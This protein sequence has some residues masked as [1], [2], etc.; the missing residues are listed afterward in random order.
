MWNDHALNTWNV[1]ED[2]EL[3]VSCLIKHATMLKYL[4]NA[5]PNPGRVRT[6]QKTHGWVCSSVS[7]QA[8]ILYPSVMRLHKQPKRKVRLQLT[9]DYSDGSETTRIYSSTLEDESP[10]TWIYWTTEQRPWCCYIIVDWTVRG[11]S[12]VI[13]AVQLKWP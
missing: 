12:R 5:C 10:M 1:C 4:R 6:P 13:M 7:Q 9:W 2:V 11:D 8:W 3:P